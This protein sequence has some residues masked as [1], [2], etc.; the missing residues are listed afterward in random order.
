MTRA[1]PAVRVVRGRYGTTEYRLRVEKRH[2]LLVIQRGYC[3]RSGEFVLCDTLRL[4]R[5]DLGSLVVA[6]ADL[7]D[8]WPFSPRRT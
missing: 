7:L 3:A 6:L 4:C 2:S 1:L 5:G 8:I